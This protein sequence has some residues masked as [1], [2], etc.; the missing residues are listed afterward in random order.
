MNQLARGLAILTSVGISL[1]ALQPQM[2]ASNSNSL[3]PR[4]YTGRDGRWRW[5]RRSGSRSRQSLALRYCIK[6][7][8]K[9]QNKQ[10]TPDTQCY[11]SVRRQGR[12]TKGED[13]QKPG[14]GQSQYPSIWHSTGPD[15][16]TRETICHKESP[17]TRT[18]VDTGTKEASKVGRTHTTLLFS[19]RGAPLLTS[20]GQ[21]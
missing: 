2:H 19:D 9:E 17:R 18:N 1:L 6:W 5:W 7:M 14:R 21:T 10:I 16:G 13:I 4:G 8:C 11:L 3:L 12:F 20:S 15:P